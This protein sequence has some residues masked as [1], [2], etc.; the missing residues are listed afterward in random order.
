MSRR[1]FGKFFPNDP[2]P[3]RNFE[4]ELGLKA[5]SGND[6]WKSDMLSVQCL[7]DHLKRYTSSESSREKYL[8][9]LL[10]FSIWSS[11]SPEKLVK[12][13]KPNAEVLVQSFTD[14]LAEKGRSKAYVNSVIKRLRTFFRVNGYSDNQELKIQCH[15][16]PTRYRKIPEYIPTK[17]QVFAMADAGGTRRNRAIILTLWNSGLRVSTLCSLNISDVAEEL[18]GGEPYIMIRVYPEMKKRTV[19]ACKGMV[20]YFTF[21]CPEAGEALRSYM[22]ERMEKYGDIASDDPLFHSDWTLWPRSER[23]KHRLGRRA[24]GLIVKKAARFAGIREWKHVTP[25]CMRKAFESVL[26]SNT[27]DG[28]RL[29]KGTQEFFMGHI[30]PGTQD[31]YYDKKVEFHRKEFAK[32]DFSRSG[33][34]MGRMVDRLID[35]S[36]LEDRLSEGWLFVA[37]IS[38]KRMVVRRSD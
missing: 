1:A 16:V 27:I 30:L 8:R 21:I 9:H 15:F 4:T 3:M 24:V 5:R 2:L 34:T 31:V 23:S 17:T 29:D 26:R 28:G 20:S 11:V 22:T 25:H 38:D 14:K 18:E 10:Q 36:E 37:K 7:L 13:P 33:T 32:L 12:L 6:A 19:D 35:V